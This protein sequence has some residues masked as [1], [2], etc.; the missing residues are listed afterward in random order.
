MTELA[1]EAALADLV[2]TDLWGVAKRLALRLNALG[3]EK[4]SSCAMP[5]RLSGASASGS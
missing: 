3:I 5:I 2:L 4:P 1:Q